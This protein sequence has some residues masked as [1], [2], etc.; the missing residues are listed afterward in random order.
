MYKSILVPFDNSDQAKNALKEAIMLAEA[1]DGGVTVITVTDVP[2]FMSDPG[3]VVAA[4]MAGVRQMD[5]EEMLNVQREYYAKAKEDLIANT[6][7]IVGDFA[8]ITYH[9]TAGKPHDAIVEFVDT[10]KY[11]LVIMGCRG[12]GGLRGALGSVS[13]A[14]VHSV[15]LPIML[16]K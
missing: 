6:A 11:D 3:F 9:A 8:N 15:Y 12:L 13:Y 2:E 5:R 14:V 1:G 16:V 7:D 10:E 4:R